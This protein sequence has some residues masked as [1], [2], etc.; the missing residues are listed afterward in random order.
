L[1]RTGR[2]TDLGAVKCRT[3]RARPV[4]IKETAPA[5]AAQAGVR[6]IR[7]EGHPYSGTN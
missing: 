6:A 4:V 5:P 1:A 7:G 2:M 3:S